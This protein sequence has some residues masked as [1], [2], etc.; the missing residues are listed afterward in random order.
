[1]SD[2]ERESK[3]AALYDF[4]TSD[5]CAQFFA[6]IDT[7]AEELLGLQVK[8]MK[9]HKA[10]WE[11]EGEIIKRIQKTQADFSNEISSIIGTAAGPEPALEE[12]E[13]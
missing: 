2:A 11:K 4:I 9:F 13:L 5:R 6:R 7:S 12:I 8:E 1:M 3:T 10:A